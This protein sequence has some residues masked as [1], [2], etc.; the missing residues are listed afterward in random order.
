MYFIKK[1]EDG[2]QKLKSEVNKASSQAKPKDEPDT[3]SDFKP[4]QHS[5][6]M[7]SSKKS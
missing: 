3:K 4:E 1:L 6:K 5:T 2:K 7:I